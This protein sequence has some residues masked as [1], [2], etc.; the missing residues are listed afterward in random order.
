MAT[1]IQIAK[2]IC[3]TKMPDEKRDELLSTL[4]GHWH[5]CDKPELGK[6]YF[7]QDQEGD[8]KVFRIET[9]SKNCFMEG[10]LIFSNDIFFRGLE[11]TIEQWEQAI[12][13]GRIKT[14]HNL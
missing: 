6:N 1:R 12:A 3:R 2:R 14:L 11:T 7:F 10:R 5:E 9:R 8:Y 4:Y 13:D